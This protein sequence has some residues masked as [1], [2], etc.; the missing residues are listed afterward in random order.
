[1]PMNFESAWIAA[2]YTD[3]PH[4]VRLDC[5]WGS[6]GLWDERG[7][8][9][10]LG[11]FPISADLRASIAAWQD[12]YDKGVPEEPG[13]NAETATHIATGTA[14]ARRL[15]QELPRC[16]VVAMRKRIRDDLSVGEIVPFPGEH[17]LAKEPESHFLR[18]RAA[19]LRGAFGQ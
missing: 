19:F 4:F 7:A 2:G 8:M 6:D 11:T 10:S 17:I 12:V 16:I 15:K 18:W 13:T 5:D 9:Y 1:M 3:W 14:L